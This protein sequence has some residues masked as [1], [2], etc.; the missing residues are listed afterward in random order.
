MP[1]A[2]KALPFDKRN[3]Q[4]F[5]DLTNRI[6]DGLALIRK[7]KSLKPTQDTLAKLAQCSR[8]TLSLRRWPIEQLK[9]IKNTPSGDDEN[10]PV[11]AT[12]GKGRGDGYET[13]L[14]TQI[15]NYQD[16]NGQLFDRVQYLEDEQSRWALI[17]TTL[18]EQRDALRE[19]VYQLENELRT[20]KL[21]I[22]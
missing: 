22:V 3:D 5:E 19:R 11:A 14:V 18:E 9:E 21:T 4:D 10:Q 6:R 7:S 17:K 12:A 16:Q 15:R 13:L 1:A 8:R 20:T 2:L